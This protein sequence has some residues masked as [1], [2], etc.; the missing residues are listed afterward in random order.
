MTY[1]NNL[2]SH[3]ECRYI[4][5]YVMIRHTFCESLVKVYA[6]YFCDI[7]SD[8]GQCCRPAQKNG[9][10]NQKS[11]SNLIYNTLSKY[12]RLLYKLLHIS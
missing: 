7:F 4:K 8:I 11:D 10:K 5:I 12:F 6:V 1:P 3:L 2:K 9:L